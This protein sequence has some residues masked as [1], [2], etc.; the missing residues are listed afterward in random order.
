MLSRNTPR[1]P[2]QGWIGLDWARA[3][4]RPCEASRVQE[5]GSSKIIE[6]LLPTYRSNNSSKPSQSGKR[7]KNWK[8]SLGDRSAV[9]PN[10]PLPTFSATAEGGSTSYSSY[11]MNSKKPN[12]L[13]WLHFAFASFGVGYGTKPCDRCRSGMRLW[14]GQRGWNNPPRYS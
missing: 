13:R 14:E 7:L 12:R 6:T 11:C 10:R 3:Y 8:L 2:T 5:T 9:H 4:A 1:V